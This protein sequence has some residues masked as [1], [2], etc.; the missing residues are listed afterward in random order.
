M[1]NT[2]REWMPL[3]GFLDRKRVTDHLADMAAKGW[4]LDRLSSW[5]WRY[6]RTEP[7]QLRFAITFF[8]GAGRFSPAPAAGLD[9]F[10][11]YCAQAGWQP[12]ASFDQVQVFYSEDPAAVDIETDPA[13]ELENIRRSLGK[14]MMRS[15]LALLLLC[16]VE[17]A[18]QCYQIWTDPVDTLASANSLLAATAYL[19]LLVLILANLFCYRRWQRR[20]GAAVEAGLP[21]PDL[22]SARGLSILV[23][24][25]SALLIAGV[26]ASLSRSAGMV[27]L[28]IGMLLFL[29]LTYFLADT[30]RKALQHL[31]C[32]PW[33]NVLV[34]ALVCAAM[35]VGGMAGLFALVMHNAGTGWLED[36]PP[37]ETYTYHDMT[38]SVYD[39]PIPLRVEDLV[40][41]DYDRWSTEAEVD[42]SPLAVHG[43]YRQEARAGEG[44]LPE[45]RYE[46]VTVQNSF[47]YDLCKRD[48]IQ[49]V[50]RDND[51]LP[52][53]DW[54]V[55]QPVDPAPWGAEE[56]LQRYRSG[57]P[58]NQ[59]LLCW[60][61]RMAE[62]DL[63]WD[64][65]LTAGQM[66][67]IGETLREA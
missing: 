27:L 6:R 39:D 24:A 64:W 3:Y 8:A 48:F 5:S 1:K 54:D 46:I 9:T 19:P 12:A 14:P 25:W 31:R 10:Q 59:F 51:Q 20:A 52:E 60:P 50:E 23:I 17:V 58:V 47:L 15:Y 28:T 38:L 55:Y 61:G 37:A 22:R 34:M 4:L 7:K 32:P 2:K 49:W 18:F 29:A 53:E 42:R 26:F 65:D 43:T 30:A 16:L 35:F 33:A 66:A 36:R 45:L 57:E 40:E 11:D 44:D 63:P 21:L 67:L 56:V 62:V 13:A 41:V